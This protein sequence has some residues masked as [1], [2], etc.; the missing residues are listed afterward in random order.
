MVAQ[1]HDLGALQ[2]EEDG[3][4]VDAGKMFVNHYTLN[5]PVLETQQWQAA[6]PT[7]TP[8]RIKAFPN[9]SF[10]PNGRRVSRTFD[11]DARA[12][13]NLPHGGLASRGRSPP[14]F[15]TP[16]SPTFRPMDNSQSPSFRGS[17]RGK[18]SISTAHSRLRSPNQRSLA[19]SPLSR[20]GSRSLPT[21]PKY[22]GYNTCALSSP[23]VEEKGFSVKD[24]FGFY[25]DPAW[26]K[27][28]DKRMKGFA[29]ERQLREQ[30]R[31]MK[32]EQLHITE[33]QRYRKQRLRFKNQSDEERAR[34]IYFGTHPMKEHERERRQEAERKSQLL[35]NLSVDKCFDMH[36]LRA[37]RAKELLEQELKDFND[38][39]PSKETIKAQ[40]MAAY[41]VGL[42]IMRLVKA[43]KVGDMAT[44]GA[45]YSE[46]KP[47]DISK[48]P[49]GTLTI[50]VSCQHLPLV[51]GKP[52]AKIENMAF[53]MLKMAK[54]K[55]KMKRL[56][57]IIQD[58]SQRENGAGKQNKTVEDDPFKSHA[59][60][61]MGLRG[62]PPTALAVVY[63]RSSRRELANYWYKLGTTAKITSASPDFNI[64]FCFT[65]QST[66]VNE[67]L[68]GRGRTF[69]VEQTRHIRVRLY[70]VD[71]NGNYKNVLGSLDFD[72]LAMMDAVE[73]T[74]KGNQKEL[75]HLKRA[76]EM[77]GSLKKDTKHS[78]RMKDLQ[79]KWVQVMFTLDYPDSSEM[80]SKLEEIKSRISLHCQVAKDEELGSIITTDLNP[81]SEH[82][83]QDC[84]HNP[85]SVHPDSVADKLNVID[86]LYFHKNDEGHF[87]LECNGHDNTAEVCKLHG[88]KSRS[89]QAS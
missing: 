4:G 14:S 24:G 73:E 48:Q 21:L 28:M 58:Q 49:Q 13:P 11:F 33:Q 62:K 59:V 65:Q 15:Q 41:K 51:P 43:R 34:E 75:N 45:G 87:E 70:N 20:R 67:V 80:A 72:T 57:S 52:V 53:G 22:T 42:N 68:Q 25:G 77:G 5:E 31:K 23:K 29:K 16:G 79:E 37:R 19:S 2:G 55:E 50:R 82:H 30:S 12:N 26:K 81:P 10:T 9:R 76:T 40:E 8:Y 69:D 64:N 6:S 84:P 1:E 7:L 32:M 38:S 61:S 18:R 89:R 36:A 17:S 35:R 56:K 54:D 78:Q 66:T 88:A 71:Q 85:I 46:E 3:V 74:E 27:S 63:Q 60:K 83:A 44:N 47:R 86:Q 39:L